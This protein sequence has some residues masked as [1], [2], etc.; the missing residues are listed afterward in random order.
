MNQMLKRMSLIIA[1]MVF[2]LPGAVP[3]GGNVNADWMG[4]ASDYISR[5]EYEASFQEKTLLKENTPCWHFANRAH[6]LRAYFTEKNLRMVRRTEANPGWELGFRILPSKADSTITGSGNEITVKRDHILEFFKNDPSGIQQTILIQKESGIRDFILEG[7]LHLGIEISGEFSPRLT[8][9][10]SL[11]FLFR[12]EPVLAYHSISARDGEGKNLPIRLEAGDSGL[13]IVIGTGGAAFPLDISAIFGLPDRDPDKILDCDQNFACFGWSVSTAGDVNGDGYADVIVGA[14]YF[15]GGHKNEGAAFVYHGSS[16]GISKY[17]YW[18]FEGEET[19]GNFGWSV[20]SAGD[21]NGDGFAD[22]IAGEPLSDNWGTVDAGAA[23]VFHGGPK[24]VS[25]KISWSRYPEEE[26]EHY[27]WSVASAGDVNGDGFYDIIVGAPLSDGELADEGYAYVYHGSASGVTTGTVSWVVNPA[28]QKNAQFGYSVA[29]AGDVNADGFA[30]VIIGAPYYGNGE[31]EEGTAY[32]YLGHSSG[33]HTAVAWQ[34]EE[35]LEGAHYGFSVSTAGDVNGDAFSDVIIGAPGFKHEPAPDEDGIVFAYYGS[36]TGLNE[37]IDWTK[38]Y[39]AGSSDDPHMGWS[40]G[41]AGDVNGDGYSDVIIGIP[42]LDMTAANVDGGMAR[43]YLGSSSGLE[44]VD[45]WTNGASRSSP[46]TKAHYGYSVATAGDVNGDGLSDVIVG[47]PYHA[48]LEPGPHFVENGYC[49]LYYGAGEK[50]VLFSSWGYPGGQ[51]NAGLGFTVATTGDVNGDGYADFLVGAP[52]YDKGQEDEGAVFVWFGSSTGPGKSY[53]W[54]AESNQPGAHFGFSA[55]TAGDVNGDGYDDVLVGAPNALNMYTD[56]GTA[57]LW[58]GGT[59]GL[60]EDGNFSNSHWLMDGKQEGAVLGSSVACAGDVNGDGFSDVILGSPGYTSVNQKDGRALVFLGSSKGLESTPHW[61]KNGGKKGDM[62]GW[63]VASAGDVNRDGF[64]DVVVGAP[65]HTATVAVIKVQQG[66]AWSYYGSPQGLSQTAGWL[67]RGHD[68][69]DHLGYSVASAGD[70]NGDGYSDIIVGLPGSSKGNGRIQVYYG[71]KDGPVSLN[72]GDFI[73]ASLAKGAALGWSVSTAG[74]IDGDGLAEILAGGPT[75]AGSGS[76]RGYVVVIHEFM[77]LVTS[78]LQLWPDRDGAGLGWSV[79]C[80]GDV[81]GDGYADFLAGAPG[82]GDTYTGE[83][84]PF[85]YYGKGRPCITK[86]PRQLRSDGSAPIARLGRSDKEDSYRLAMLGKSPFGRS[87]VMMEVE[88]KP[89]YRNFDRS[90]VMES[91]TWVDSKK[92]LADMEIQMLGASPGVVLHWRA[93]TAYPR[94]NPFGLVHSYWV[95][96]PWNGWNEADFRMK[97]SASSLPQAD[98]T[99]MTPSGWAPLI[100]CFVDH[101][102]DNGPPIFSWEW[103]FENDGIFDALPQ[104]PCTM[105]EKPGTYSVRLKV[106]N[107]SGSDEETKTDFITANYLYPMDDPQKE[108]WEP[109]PTKPGTFVNDP[110]GAFY[111]APTTAQ[112]STIGIV[113]QSEDN[114]YGYWQMKAGTP[115]KDCQVDYLYRANYSLNTNQKD[116]DK[117]PMIRLRWSDMPSLSMGGLFVDH[118]PNAPVAG[119]RNFP[120]IFF[121]HSSEKPLGEELLLYFDL[122]DFTKNQSGDLFCNSIEVTRHDVPSGGALAA[123]YVALTDFQT[124]TFYS[125]PGVLDEVKHGLDPGVHWT[126]ALW[127]ESPGPIGGK[128]LYYGGWSSPREGGTPQFRKDRLYQVIITLGSESE[129]ARKTLPMIRLRFS[130]WT[131]DWMVSREIRQV[132]G[133]Y[134]HMPAVTG[135]EYVLYLESPPYLS[136]VSGSPSDSMAINFDIVDGDP[137][138]EGRVNLHAVEIYEHDLPW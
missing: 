17:P 85:L 34:G 35:N 50:L 136:E 21:V 62:Y 76:G 63:S 72:G 43:I 113:N 64:S 108:G 52:Y 134:D 74:D 49:Y 53:D 75:A 24:G 18:K 55:G 87:K 11:E 122:V 70:V 82:F 80:A 115:M 67:D 56:E 88:V 126:S 10:R 135:S 119:W 7:D 95:T 9:N 36:L 92:G 90:R 27:G 40:V 131:F 99:A 96:P 110:L 6:D 28:D 130:N 54:M 133:S 13:E 2:V 26:M 59:D 23:Y 58:Y 42:H 93:R 16:T 81:N 22:V 107:A 102:L 103:D 109:A 32:V 60:G 69:A 47:A 61:E 117:V 124:W 77:G 101:S 89:L 94:G 51:E 5:L 104:H 98:F 45:F 120:S 83:G 66:G 112:A 84:S 105:Y 15:D 33:L 41:C 128:N 138:Q 127:V 39:A 125:A 30:D 114:A 73:W 79:A 19:D 8:S 86:C 29:G 129:E 68:E 123:H 106:T 111:F 71:S 37:T 91:G 100:V 46:E 65:F 118:G 97:P 14:P 121:K 3:A 25:T 31:K 20:A 12:E 57:A 78:H 44:S 132:P 48:A 1:A 137:V 116:P 4:A 38:S